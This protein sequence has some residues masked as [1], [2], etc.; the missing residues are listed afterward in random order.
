MCPACL[1]TIVGAGVG[2]AGAAGA[3]LLWF[4]QRRKGK[5]HRASGP[6]SASFKEWV[7]A[8]CSMEEALRATNNVNVPIVDQ[9]STGLRSVQGL[10]DEQQ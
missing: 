10:Y 2:S 1:S 4:Q 3:L 5:C 8:V 6:P 9:H 7:A